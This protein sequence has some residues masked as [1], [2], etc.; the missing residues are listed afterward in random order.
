MFVRNYD[1][2]LTM[3]YTIVQYINISSIKVEFELSL[4]KVHSSIVIKVSNKIQSCVR[5]HLRE[6][7][8]GTIKQKGATTSLLSHYLK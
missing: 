5:N 8:T 7:T 1:V 4:E 3:D 6:Q 2:G